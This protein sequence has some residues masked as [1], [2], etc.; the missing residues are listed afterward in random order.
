MKEDLRSRRNIK[1]YLAEKFTIPF[2]D[3]VEST[4]KIP[5]SKVIFS[6]P[7]G[8]GKK[9]SAEN[10]I[11]LFEAY[12]SLTPEDASDERFWAYLT[13]TDLFDYMK[14]RTD[15]EAQSEDKRGK[16]I[17]DHWFVDPMS[18]ASLMNNDIS[19]LWWVVFLTKTNNAKD[20]YVLTRE[21]F[22]M[23]DY[24]THLLP[25]TQGRNETIRFAVFEFVVENSSL[26]S[27]NKEAKVRLIMR[28]LNLRGGY[29]ALSSLDSAQM[30][31]LLKETIPELKKV[32]K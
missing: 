22:S 28:K 3:T 31:S 23:L 13:H 5:I 15:V 30:K 6:D 26:F 20:P 29:S 11:K 8:G 4:S 21:V 2:G 18:P 9:D 24:T 19:R 25:G 27:K 17:L 1:K 12:S 10:A 32:M 14:K 16:Y 7:P